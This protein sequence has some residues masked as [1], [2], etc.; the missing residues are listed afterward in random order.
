M[1]RGHLRWPRSSPSSGPGSDSSTSA[2]AGRHCCS[3]SRSSWCWSWSPSSR[4]AALE[5]LVLELLTPS[6]ALTILI[7][8]VL[9]GIWRLVSMAEAL[10]AAGPRGA[11][12][13]PVPL[14]TFVVLAAIVIA[15]HAG[16]ANLALSFYDAGK[17]IFVGVQDPDVAPTPSLAAVATPAPGDDGR[18]R[19]SDADPACE[20]A[21]HQH[22][23][24]R[25]RFELD[26]IARPERHA[27]RGQHRSDDRRDRD[28]Q[29]PP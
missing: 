22:P 7:L 27:D 26:P 16:A 6:T 25:H 8:I 12:R 2:L 17:D 23:A 4:S 29:L 20:A 13:R 18:T 19:D 10:G 24:D 15:T 14:T 9:L 11:W 21:A 28:G 3:P 5:N 1:L